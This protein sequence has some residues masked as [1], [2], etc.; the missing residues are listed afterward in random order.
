MK[1]EELKYKFLNYIN[2][3]GVETFVD[4][5]VDVAVMRHWQKRF[6][7][8]KRNGKDKR[9]ALEESKRMEAVLDKFLDTVLERY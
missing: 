5:M 6:F 2:R 3:N 4:R 1:R 9:N 8:L 7:T